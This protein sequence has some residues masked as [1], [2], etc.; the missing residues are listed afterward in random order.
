MTNSQSKEY[1]NS[2]EVVEYS[3]M[4]DYLISEANTIIEN[5]TMATLSKI[6]NCKNRS[7]IGKSQIH[8]KGLFANCDIKKGEIIT[9]YPAHYVIIKPNGYK[10]ID[11]KI[12][13]ISIPSSISIG[14]EH[15]ECYTFVID[16]NLS[17]CGDPEDISNSDFLAHMAND[18]IKYKS[19]N[20]NRTAKEIYNDLAF[21]RNNSAIELLDPSCI[22]IRAIK[23]INK[24]EEITTPY[25]YQ[26]WINENNKP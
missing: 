11:G 20:S 5:F 10:I 25:G 16:E 9:Y 7:R 22:Y 26:F 13:R 21:K 12:E 14:T 18:G 3:S 15:N 4:K 8:G 2:N 24:D 6:N 17:I 19:K 23:D 1:N